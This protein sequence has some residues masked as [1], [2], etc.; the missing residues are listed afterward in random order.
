V[1]YL[2]VILLVVC[3]GCSSQ[4]PCGGLRDGMWVTHKPTGQPAQVD[5][6]NF[7]DVRVKLPNGQWF[8]AECSEISNGGPEG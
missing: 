1:K 8:N 2:T 7:Y 4:P 5:V 6:Y 3:A